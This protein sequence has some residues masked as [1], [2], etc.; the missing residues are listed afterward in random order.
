MKKTPR[1]DEGVSLFLAVL[2]LMLLS[3]IGMGLLY[4]TDT[5]TSINANYRSSQQAYFAAMAGIQEVRDRLRGNHP[6]RITPPTALPGAP[7]SVVY[8]INPAGGSDTVNPTTS[9][10]KYFD[11]QLC[12]QNYQGLGLSDPGVNQPC[13][14]ASSASGVYAPYVT[15]VAPFA[16]TVAALPF[17]WVRIT[18]KANNTGAPFYVDD[19]TNSATHNT[20]VCWNGVREALLPAGVARCELTSM[21]SVYVLTSHARGSRRMTQAEVARIQLPRLP[22]ALTLAGPSPAYG[23]PSSNSF[24]VNGNDGSGTGTTCGTVNMPAVGAVD[25]AADA[26]I[27]G[28]IPSNR[29]D[30]YVGIGGA[31]TDVQNV[32]PELQASNLNT[33][34][35]LENVVSMVTEYANQVLTGPISNPNLGSS[36][37]PLIT[38]VNGDLTLSGTT[39]GAGILL[40]TGTLT[41]N[42]NSSFNGIV[43]VIGQGVWNV[44]GG[45]SGQFNGAVLVA[46]TR[47]PA[48]ALL[49]NPGLPTLN[50]AGGGGN[51]IY[52]DSCSINTLQNNFRFTLITSRELNY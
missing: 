11:D 20:P 45:G 3:A 13:T 46:R 27:S 26:S 39:S 24:Y 14:A 1:K 37:N 43:L 42:G 35:G 8:V 25:N 15:S 2:A 21:T 18:M 17:K 28:A 9:G 4:M 5:E 33:V 10:S 31:Y 16:N 49:A 44:S 6:Q 34:Q 23:A 47:D 40:V 7:S 29:S 22:A 48:G 30:H 36:A 52:Y 19:G 12:K 32:Y 51:G 50:W 38:V 41:S